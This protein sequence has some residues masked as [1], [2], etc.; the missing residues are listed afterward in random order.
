MK[1]FTI[2]NKPTLTYSQIFIFFAGVVFA[3]SV[4]FAVDWFHENYTL[5]SPLVNPIQKRIISPVQEGDD[6][7]V[8][9]PP[10]T[11]KTPAPGRISRGSSV[12]PL[13]SE[14]VANS[15][16][17][18][19]IDHIWF[20]ESGRGSNKEGLSGYCLDKGL[21]NEFGFAVSVN[22]CFP[23]F[24]SSVHRL[25]KWYEEDSKGLS[26]EAK[27]CYYNGAG[28]VSDCPY[29]TLDFTNME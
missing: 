21:S 2:N 27:L 25:E 20:R 19:F 1:L 5:R 13:P 14:I 6:V 12:S 7:K 10:P 18:E 11:T 29:L 22:H 26:Y 8:I 3:T 15:K 17:P 24:E 23:D 9:S 28:K 4:I 16:Y